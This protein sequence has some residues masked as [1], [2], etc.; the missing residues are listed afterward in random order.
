MKVICEPG[1]MQSPLP[2]PRIHVLTQY[3]WACFLHFP[4]TFCSFFLQLHFLRGVWSSL[5][6]HYTTLLTKLFKF[7]L[8]ELSTIICPQHLD[9]LLYLIFHQSFKFF[10]IVEYF[11]FL[12]Q[13]IYLCIPWEVIY[14]WNIVHKLSQWWNRHMSKHIIVHKL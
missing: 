4:S 10:K 1:N 6:P 13:E 3:H 7:L 11:K 8:I 14:E 9:L 5:L 2:L 12:P